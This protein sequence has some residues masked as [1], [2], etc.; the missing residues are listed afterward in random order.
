MKFDPDQDY[1]KSRDSAGSICYFQNGHK[2]N[3]GK[4]HVGKT[5]KGKAADVVSRAKDK[6]DKLKDFKDLEN[7]KGIA[8]ALKE[9]RAAKAAEDNA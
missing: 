6:V 2:F 5:A 9:D 1:S 8:D 4:R 7:P 3:A